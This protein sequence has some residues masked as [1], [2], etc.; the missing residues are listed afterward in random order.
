MLIRRPRIAITGPRRGGRMLT[1]LNQLAVWRVGGKPVVVYPGYQSLFASVDGF[2][3]GGG[4]DIDSVLYDDK[5]RFRAIPD[6]ARDKLELKG[7]ELAAKKNLPVLGICRGSQLMNVHRG[8]TLNPDSYGVHGGPGR[9]RSAWPRKTV[10]I[11]PW[12]KIF[13]LI[14]VGDQ[15]RVNCL[16]HQSVDRLGDGLKVCA[17][18]TLGLTQGTEDPGERFFIG[19]QWHPEILVWRRDQLNIFRGLV[20]ASS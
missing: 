12:S 4:E 16:H 5:L 18:D 1:W 8:G 6:K 19:V 13:S 3:I 7:L 2:L 14:G 9:Y 20:Q 10:R 17:Q 15:I 11:A